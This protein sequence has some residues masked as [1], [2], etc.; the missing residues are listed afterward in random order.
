MIGGKKGGFYHDDI[1]NMKYLKK[2]KWDDLMQQ[3]QEEARE[4]EG[5]LRAALQQ[6]RRER[7][8]FLQ[9]VESAKQVRGMEAKRAAK[10]KETGGGR[11]AEAK[12][13]V[14]AEKT[15]QRLRKE[16]TY[17][18]HKLKERDMSE[19]S[20]QPEEVRKIMRQIF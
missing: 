2:F 3:V 13:E 9:N 17:E 11:E 14:E 7:R 18:Q 15:E 6:E 19:S 1:W 10:K 5:K 4:R 16:T 20:G 8:Y 12:S